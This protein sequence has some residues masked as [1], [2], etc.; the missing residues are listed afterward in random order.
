MRKN[1]FLKLLFSAVTFLAVAFQACAELNC[2]KKL[3]SQ[4]DA[5]ASSGGGTLRLKAGTYRTGALFFKPGVNLHLEKDAVILGVDEGK[6]YPKRITRIEGETC[7]YYPALIN[8]DKCDGFTITGEGV[9]DGHGANTWEEF[10][11]G[12]AKARKERKKFFNK[13]PMRP[14]LLYVSRSKNVDISGVTFKNSK[15]WTTHFYDCDNVIVHD[16][17][18]LAEK[19]LDSKGKKISGPSTDAIDIDKCRGFVVRNVYMSVNDDGVAIKGGKGP[20][21]DDYVKNPGNGPSTDVLIEGCTFASPTHHALTLGS[22]CPA[23]TNIVMRNCKMA[24]CGCVLYLKMRTDTPQHY[25][26]VLVENCTG[27]S[28]VFFQ[29]M[30]WSQYHDAKGRS[31]QEVF[32]YADNIKLRNNVI[33]ARRRFRISKNPKV[34][35]IKNLV[36]ENNIINGKEAKIDL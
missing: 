16:C 5:I 14:R 17:R 33:K 20:W 8:A 19:L 21:A 1:S 32:S 12:Y 13:T 25:S 15:F 9:I 31:A 28:G 30:G 36:L 27:K 7:E 26:D 3:Q 29:A 24:G 23:A 6:W 11:T 4:I 34:W 18:I 22:E 2:T 10:W 35:Q